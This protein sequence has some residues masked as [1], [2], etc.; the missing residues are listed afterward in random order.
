MPDWLQTGTVRYILEL[1]KYVGSHIWK[2][3]LKIYNPDIINML[4]LLAKEKAFSV[5]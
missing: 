1:I 2:A 3:L 4:K 5:V